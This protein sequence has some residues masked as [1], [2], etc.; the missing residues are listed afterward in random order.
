MYSQWGTHLTDP[1]WCLQCWT[2]LLS[3]IWPRDTE[4]SNVPLS[5]TG[6]LF[7]SQSQSARL[8]STKQFCIFETLKGTSAWDRENPEPHTES[9]IWVQAYIDP[10][11]APLPKDLFQFFFFFYISGH[12]PTFKSI[13]EKSARLQENCKGVWQMLW[14]MDPVLESMLKL[15]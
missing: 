9:V 8:K 6:L 5:G 11:K 12:W 14:W 1:L 2:W 10:T 15:K 4:A 7:F 3:D 13:T